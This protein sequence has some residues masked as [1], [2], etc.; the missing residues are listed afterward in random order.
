[1]EKCLRNGLYYPFYI[2]DAWKWVKDKRK[3]NGGEYELFTLLETESRE[4]AMAKAKSTKLSTDVPE[5]IVRLDTGEDIEWI[6]TID[7]S[8][9][10][11]VKEA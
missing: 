1:M 3:E 11:D 8:G 2:V 10:Y 6:C 7:E 9:L 5:V 4:E